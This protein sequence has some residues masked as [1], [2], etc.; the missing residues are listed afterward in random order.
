M[1]GAAPVSVAYVLPRLEMGGTE[2]HVRDLV[3]RLD[4]S[5]F[6][7]LVVATSEGGVLESDFARMG[8]PVH[9]LGYKGLTRRRGEAIARLRLALGFLGAMIGI[10]KEDKVAIVHAYLPAANVIGA[11]AGLLARTPRIV[12]S[13]RGLCHYKKERPILAVLENAANLAADAVMVN[14]EAVASAVRRAERFWG[15]KIRLIY[16]GIDGAAYDPGLF[17]PSS[18]PTVP[19]LPLPGD[20]ARVLC[21]ANLFPYEGHLDLVEAA[22]RVVA[23]CP[24]AHFLLAGRDSGAMTAVRARIETLG[25]DGHVHLLGPRGDVPALLAAADIVVHPSHEEGFPNVLLEAMAAAKAVAATA[26]GGVPEAVVDGETGILVPPRDPERMAG[27]ILALL[28][29]PGRARAMGE[30]GRR[31]VEESF[32]LEKTVREVEAMYDKLLSGGRGPCAA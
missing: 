12:V 5:R 21:V 19:G 23:R 14:S 22:A 4:R 20:A 30:A 25:L 18:P 16:N 29:D 10:L 7:P 17:P 15:S 11:L 9:V 8:V 3:A 27:A 31:R 28:S 2:K 1:T 13:K 24:R 32:L 26:V 6:S